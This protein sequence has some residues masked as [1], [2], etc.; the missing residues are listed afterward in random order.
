MPVALTA[1]GRRKIARFMTAVT[2]EARTSTVATAEALK[3]AV[4]TAAPSP[5]QEGIMLSQGVSQRNM[6]GLGFGLGLFGTPEGGRFIRQGSM[7]SLREAIAREPIAVRV[8]GDVIVAGFGS[9]ARINEVT[10]FYWQTRRRGIMGPTLP[11]NG[12]YVQAVENGGL[13]WTVVPR[14]GTKAL[15]PEPGR[16]AFRMLKTIAPQRMFRGTLFA[17]R[18]QV[19]E[20]TV[21]ALRLAARGAA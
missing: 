1:A 6:G 21:A 20:R 12:A 5:E 10:G 9:P 16:I 19:L 15:E 13:V 17:R 11:F 2:K 8:T 3:P 18:A 4:V 14:P 7:V